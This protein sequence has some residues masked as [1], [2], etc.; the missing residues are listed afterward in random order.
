M[1]DKL[2][3]I[4]DYEIRSSRWASYISW[5]WGQNMAGDYFAWKVH[6]KY[7]RYQESIRMSIIIES[8]K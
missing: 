2:K 8:L 5:M 1:D 7:K 6:R 3:T 4:L